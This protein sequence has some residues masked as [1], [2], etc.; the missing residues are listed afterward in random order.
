V[1]ALVEFL[2]KYRPVVFETGHIVFGTSWPMRLL[3]LAL[4]ALVIAA[5]VTYTR[6]RV[7]GAG[8]DRYVL[9]GIRTLALLLLLFVLLRPVLLASRDVVGVL[10]DD[11]R[12]MQLPDMKG[13]TRADVVRSLL[14]SPDSSLYKALTKRK[15]VVRLYSLGS[16]GSHITRVADLTFDGAHTRFAPALEG[17][18]QELAD[19]PLAGLVLVSDGADN[20]PDSLNET[21]AALNARH[22]PVYT[23]GVGQEQFAKDIEISRVGAPR[24]ALKG[25]IVE[26]DVDIT[27]RGFGG[28][29]AQLAVLDSGR[30]VSTEHV[31]LPPD[32]DATTVRVR[33]PVNTAGPHLFTVR[34]APR[35]GEMVRENNEQTALV[36]VQDRKDK[37]L[38]V[39]GEPRFE[40]KF[41]ILAVN[42]DANLQLITMV[43]VGLDRFI[44]LNVDD[45]TELS[46][47]FPETREELFSYRGIVL[48]SV[49]ASSFTGDQLRMISDFVSERGGG[50]LMLGGRSSFAEGGY[51]GT[52]VADA[53]PVE[54]PNGRQGKPF[55]HEVKVNLT[56]AGSIVAQTQIAGSESESAKK[57]KTMPVVTSVNDIGGVKP[58]ATT[59]LDGSTPAGG[60]HSIVL[61]SQRYGR[62]KAAAFAIQDSWLWQMR[63]DTPVEDVT[64][65]T[66]WRQTLRWLVSDVPDRVMVSTATDRAWINEP[67]Q[68]NARVADRAYR[69]VDNADV[70]ATIST[71]SGSVFQQRLVPSVTQ[72]GSIYHLT[73]TPTERGVYR[74]QVTARPSSDSVVTSQPT[75]IDV[76]TPST[77]FIGAGLHASLLR[78]MAEETGGRYYTAAAAKNMVDDIAPPAGGGTAVERLDL[79]DM[80]VV[81][82]LLL[83]LLAGEWG[84]RRTRGLA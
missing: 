82:L 42:D 4:G 49:E 68:V 30:I 38:Y 9:A 3:V 18:R 22:I 24:A 63:N 19:V 29:T 27:Q 50:L 14:G 66:F 25:G 17:M 77:E 75:F 47:G 40:L 83:S 23:V 7:R 73:Y 10:I 72:D 46:D 65:Q 80:P 33:V 44:R 71:P 35:P 28:D 56:P 78:R 21:L 69:H 79:W 76:G 41:V 26:M 60:N 15:R 34:I 84:Y 1:D 36:V 57:W 8:A 58:G 62:G 5:A 39:E 74:I 12:S 20:M 61:A 6:V 16:S 51:A 37:I 70:T 64:Y 32:G 11:S 54:L 13:R 67:L 52:P 59:L 2:F 48:G 55:F 43:R 31:I 45:G 81:L 53:L